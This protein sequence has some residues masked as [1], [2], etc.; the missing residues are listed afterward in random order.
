MD[1]YE[2]AK[3][4]LTELLF[5]QVDYLNGLDDVDLAVLMC[6]K[7]NNIIRSDFK[8][9]FDKGFILCDKKNNLINR[10]VLNK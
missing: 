4:T 10:E 7:Y 9:I 3:I 5:M 1:I 8:I 6:E 2:D